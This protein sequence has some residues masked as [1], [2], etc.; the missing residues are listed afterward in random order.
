MIGVTMSS[1]RF[2]SVIEIA[3]VNPFVL[4]TAK[5]AAR[6]RRGW[7]RPLPV[8]VRVNGGPDEPWRVNLMPVGDGSF[9]LYLDGAVRK[10]S[11]TKVGDAISVELEFDAEY[12]GGPAHPMPSW[13]RAALNRNRRARQGWSRLIPS[14]RKEI[15][16]YFSR[17]KSPKA[18][19]R[20]VRRAIA[21]L[22]GGK[23][24]YLARSWNES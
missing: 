7:R 2:R 10:A 12:R 24:R 14:R 6:L 9:R 16:R 1:V 17:L 4:V 20:N 3:G 5:H 19:A 18:R 22:S 13:F 11:D 23:K 15:L 21:V 8:R